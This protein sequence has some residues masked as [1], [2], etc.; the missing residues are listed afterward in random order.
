MIKYKEEQIR[1]VANLL[2]NLTVKGIE[3][4]KRIAIIAQILD[5]GISDNEVKQ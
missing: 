2:D 5:E 3:N 1:N 4:A